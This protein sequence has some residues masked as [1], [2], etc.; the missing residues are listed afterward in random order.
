MTSETDYR[1]IPWPATDVAE[2]WWFLIWRMQWRMRY[3]CRGLP[4]RN[5]EHHAMPPYNTVDNIATSWMIRSRVNFFFLRLVEDSYGTLQVAKPVACG[6]V[7]CVKSVSTRR[8][9]RSP[10]ILFNQLRPAHHRC[11]FPPTF[12]VVISLAALFS[13]I[14]ITCSYLERR[15]C[16]S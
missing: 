1:K 14:F 9:F 13:S 6:S 8:S 7:H 11:L 5:G 2:P 16:V 10:C 3:S 4:T 15:F 12:I